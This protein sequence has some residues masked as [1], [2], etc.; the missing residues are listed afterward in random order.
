MESDLCEQS[1]GTACVIFQQYPSAAFVSMRLHSHKKN[2]WAVIL[3]FS[4]LLCL[5]LPKF[6]ISSA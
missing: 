3:I 4:L 6:V 2:F 5:E 1:H